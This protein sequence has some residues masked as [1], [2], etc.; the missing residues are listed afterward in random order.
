MQLLAYI[1]IYPLLWIISIMPFKILYGISDVFCFFLYSVFGYRKKTV[2]SNLKLV[3]PNK[4]N[5]EIKTITHKFYHH[6]CDMIL[7]AI[8]SL[9]I[10]EKELKKRYTFTNIE[11]INDFEKKQKSIILMCAHYGNWEWIFIAQ[12]YINYK[13]HAV[14]KKLS[15]VYFDRLVKR[16]RAKYNTYLISN[17]EALNV[18]KTSCEKGELSLNGFISDQTPKLDKAYHWGDFMGIKV[19][20]HT[21]AEFL[22]KSLDMP[23]VFFAVKRIKRGYYQTTFETI[24]E[25]PNS[26]NNYEI[27]DLYFKLVEKQIHEAP[28][29]YL[30]THKR[31]KHKNQIPNTLKQAV[32]FPQ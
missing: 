27:T 11:L 19:P 4:T 1:L 25:H 23:V 29:Y 10:S 18:L 9:T 15:N 17:K 21:G 24:T 6:L 30:W 3:F 7:E 2:S 22:A 12:R 20:M 8:K 31:W 26:F 5:T 16:I 14:Y 32:K 28:E 13:G